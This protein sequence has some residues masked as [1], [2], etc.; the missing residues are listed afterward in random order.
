MNNGFCL[1]LLRGVSGSGKSTIASLFTDAML[2]STDDYFIDNNGDYV[3]DAN[4]LVVNH[5]KCQN[6]VKSAMKEAAD[7]L[8]NWE[9]PKAEP[10]D[11]QDR[12]NVMPIPPID[13]TIVVHNTFTQEWEMDAYYKLAEE[14][15]FTVHT[16]IVENRHGSQSTHDVPLKSIETQRDRFEVVI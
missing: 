12:W 5:E 14:H 13:C 6:D 15:G 2:F 4:N 7:A 10:V 16:L 11:D 9:Y 1:V 3:F 8:V